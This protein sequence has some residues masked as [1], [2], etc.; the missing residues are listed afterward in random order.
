M[1]YKSKKSLIFVASHLKRIQMNIHNAMKFGFYFL[2]FLCIVLSACKNEARDTLFV[3]KSSEATGISF[4][5]QI[6][7][8]DSANILTEEYI[9]NGGGIA[10]G[11][12]NNDSLMDLFFAGNQVANKLYINKG[13]FVFDDISK[14]AHIEASNRWSTA[15]MVID[16]NSDGLLDIYVCSAREKDLE[17][18]SNLLF[19]NQ[20]ID[21][22]GVPVFKELAQEYGIAE[23]GNSMGA[24]FFDYD[25]DGDLDLYIVNNEQVHVLP[26]NY[27]KKVTDGSAVSNDRLYRNNGNGSFTDVTIEAGITIE[28][29]GL[30]VGIADLNYDTWPDIYVTN[31]YLTN[32]LL[33]INN[34]DG[35]FSNNIESRIKHQ[36]KFAMGSDIAD[37]NNDGLLDIV[38]LDMLGETNQRMKTTIMGH[39]YISYVLDRRYDYEPQYM[40]N[41]LQLGNGPD[42][43]FSEIGLLAG[44]AK[45]DWSWSPLFIDVDNDGYRDLLITNG[46]PRDI[47]DMDF[48]DFNLT[49]NQFLSPAK[50]IDS[51]PIVKI[52]NYG[53]KNKGDLTF[54][55]E[56][57]NWGLDIPSFSNGAV[58]V[59]LDN[60][61][62]MDYVV[63]NI[64]DQAFVFENKLNKTVI[65]S[66]YLKIAL[67]GSQNNT[68][69]IGAK[70]VVR[71]K[72][73]K[74][75][76]HEHHLT[77][78]YMSSVD[79]VIHFGLGSENAPLTI[80]VLWP[81]GRFQSLENVK[82]DQTIVLRYEKAKENN[83]AALRFPLI[84]M[85]KDPIYSEVSKAMGIDM[86][87][88]EQDI[89]DYNI[90]TVLPHKLSQNGPCIAVGDINGDSLE[91]FIIGSSSKYSPIMFLQNSDG[92]FAEKDLF[93]DKESKIYE[94]EGMVLFDLEN[95]GDL[96][97]YLVSGSNEF[98]LESDQYNDRLFINDGKGKFSISQNK[99]PR[100]KAN[101]SVVKAED[102]DKDG[103]VDLFVGGR[104]PIGQF[105]VADKSYLLKNNNGIL[106]DVTENW[107]P[108]LRNIGMITDAV[109]I[110]ANQDNQ[111]DLIVV[112]EF[113]EV[114]L[115]ENSG[116]V[117]VKSQDTGFENHWG[118]WESIVSADFDN[119]GD[120]DLLI[121]NMGNN[122]F[123]QPTQEHPV[124][125]LAK[126]YD[127]N[128]SIDPILFSYQR[129]QDGTY[130][131]YPVS[132]WSDLSKQSPLFRSKFNF[133]KEYAK[134]TIETL[135]NEEERQG[136]LVLKGNFDRSIYAENLGKG[137]FKISELPVKAQFGPINDF[138][139]LDF[140]D[141]SNL[142]VL[143]VGN[144]FGNETFIG[145]YDALNGLLL[146]GNGKGGFEV[147]DSAKSGFLAPGDA[148]SIASVKTNLGDELFVVGQNRD[149]LL[150]FVKK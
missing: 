45:T 68:L 149:S 130:N 123:Y 52:P 27:R 111:S 2:C 146:K 18:R 13:G 92:T 105:P 79:P 57:A 54:T 107:A 43:P 58:F 135:L 65:Q 72:N 91:D 147:V 132:F 4:N 119:D 28:G 121:G 44:I 80:E 122:N 33:Y 76:Y 99:M 61:G 118:W 26:T 64:N 120:D 9:F 140:N 36:G 3:L 24:S 30:S 6:I 75:Q 93:E 15:P 16:I 49:V 21:D 37:Y 77:R 38:T 63:N 124:T 84:P 39:N 78:G 148:K 103:Y 34:G 95:D 144:D 55:D 8:T 133:Y 112:G 128:G 83:T 10:V 90:Q 89:V 48:A 143:L 1:L 53:Y 137:K 145:R 14:K 150:I 35:T 106:E 23:K 17:K 19:V 41:M 25:L 60:D 97:L 47:T 113:M 12:F 100:I 109:W 69:G 31:D 20:G 62:D 71:Q 134:A 66:H 81:D 136:A 116:S 98:P 138:A 73:E 7:E 74:F 117:L 40:R 88:R 127:N 126:D 70:L 96:D 104:T 46:F 5:N 50:I 29:F 22:S 114:T 115:F 32:D 125:V 51:I 42:L 142:D 139:V 86:V 85:K 67:Q 101:G 141:D 108:E 11:D 129:E 82:T 94:E 56:G 59:D 110:D 102:F 87:H 131:S